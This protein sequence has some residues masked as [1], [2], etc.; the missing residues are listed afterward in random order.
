M[1]IRVEFGGVSYFCDTLEEAAALG[2]LL[3]PATANGRP[4]VPE[5]VV[6]ANGHQPSIASLVQGLREGPRRLLQ[7]VVDAGGEIEHG[8]LFQAFGGNS[9]AFGGFLAAITKEANRQGIEPRA[10]FQRIVRSTPNGD[11]ARFRIPASAIDQVR[12]GLNAQV[13]GR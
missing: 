2:R 7:L 4:R 9:S 11:V 12:A 13:E 10:F 5:P 1:S 3:M 8:N 6:A